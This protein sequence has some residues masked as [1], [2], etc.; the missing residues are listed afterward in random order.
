MSKANTGAPQK[1]VNA[2]EIIKITVIL[3]VICV[4]VAALLAGTN[5]LTED[6]IA[7][8][9]A[10]SKAQA[11]RE[12]L[13]AQEYIAIDGYDAYVAVS[14][15]DVVGAVIT[16]SDKGYGGAVEVL[17]GIDMSGNIT[18]VSMLSHSETPGLGANTAKP[19]Y[20]NRYVT[21]VSSGDVRPERFA[22]KKDGGTIDAWTAATI[23]SR[24]VT[25]AVNSACDVF[26]EL[27]EN[28]LLVVPSDAVSEGD[29]AIADENDGG[30][31]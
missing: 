7:E 28:N 30:E 21:D 17:V 4:I 2:G 5:M 10:I 11:C 15:S 14:G 12:V 23:S 9:A 8:N 16:S 20:L 22:V 29:A 19:E 25:R 6:K 27:V 13:P 18:G 1:K 3:T 24:A 26:D 31:E